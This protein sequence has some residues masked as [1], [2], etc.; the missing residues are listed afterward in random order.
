MSDGLGGKWVWLDYYYAG[1]GRKGERITD[2]PPGEPHP[3]Q[4]KRCEVCR[5]CELDSDTYTCHE[6]KNVAAMQ[7]E[8]NQY[9]SGMGVGY[10]PVDFCFIDEL[11]RTCKYWEWD[12]HG[13]KEGEK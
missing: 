5:F 11:K 10:V 13:K 7:D 3:D 8:T 12:G 2:P 9:N 6:P 4:L 1:N